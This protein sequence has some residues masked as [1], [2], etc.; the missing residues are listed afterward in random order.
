MLMIVVAERKPLQA[1]WRGGEPKSYDL[2]AVTMGVN[3]AGLKMFEELGVG[4]RPPKTT[5]TAIREYRL[6][7]ETIGRYFGNSMHVFLLDI[8]KLE[9]AA[10][11]PKGDHTT[12]CLIGDDIDAALLDNF[13][14]A[15]EV[16]DCFPPDWK[17]DQAACQC[18]P[19]INVRGSPQPYADGL[20][21]IGD[22]VVTRLYKDGI[23]AAYRAAKAAASTVV[24]H[25]TSA[26]D[27]RR[28]Y[29]PAC[30]KMAGDNSIG[31]FMFAFTRQIQR[32]RFAR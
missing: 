3:T 15:P 18:M 25:G 23:G 28:H 6:G 19:R 29:W 1:R 32:R 7:A 12:V 20:V 14:T 27:L 11:I 16:K 9:F 8:P 31:L 21:F 30:H 22:S 2:V 26:D 10:I 13:L 17:W 5:Q 4:Y 24:F